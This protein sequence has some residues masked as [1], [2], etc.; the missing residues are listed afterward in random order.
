MY[1]GSG[2]IR[3][4]RQRH[5]GRTDGQKE[6]KGYYVAIVIC[7][8]LSVLVWQFHQNLL[9]CGNGTDQTSKPQGRANHLT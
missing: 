4:K 8:L 2:A 9:V 6:L 7:K 1:A 3:S 5:V